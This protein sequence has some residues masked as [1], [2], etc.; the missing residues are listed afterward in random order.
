MVYSLFRIKTFEILKEILDIFYIFTPYLCTLWLFSSLMCTILGVTSKKDEKMSLR[1]LPF[2]SHA[3]V[4][5]V[6]FFS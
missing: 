2:V 5:L 1:T 4:T 3:L 6:S